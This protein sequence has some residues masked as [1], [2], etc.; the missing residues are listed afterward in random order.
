MQLKTKEILDYYKFKGR[1]NTNSFIELLKSNP[2]VG[3]QGIHEGQQKIIDAYEE[4]VEPSAEAKS[5]GLEFEYKYSVLVAAC[6]RRFGKSFVTAIIGAA[7]LLVPNSKTMVVSLTLDNAGV[8]FDL[9]YKILGGLG[10]IDELTINRRRDMELE[11]PNGSTLRVASVENV[12]SKLGS[13]ISLLILDEARLFRK[14]LY[15]Q[16]LTPMLLDFS[17][18]SRVLLISS[19]SP[20]WFEEA[21]NQGQSEDPKWAKHWSINLPTHTNPTI[22]RNILKEYE[23]TMPKA[24]YEQEVL[25]LF[26]SKHGAVFPEFDQVN[27]V[28]SD[29]DFPYFSEWL[30]CGNVIIQTIDSGYSHFFASQWIV[31]VEEVDTYFVF[32]E[33]MKN[34]TLTP[35]HAENI[36]AIE[37]D[38]GIQDIIQL[39][40]AD[41]AAS[42]QLADF[43]E[44]GLYYTKAEK[45]LRE[46]IN[47]LNTLLFQRSGVTGKPR[48]LIHK[49]CHETIRQLNEVQWKE[50]AAG[51][52]REQS[53]QGVK[54]FK[55][56]T[57]NDKTDW[58]LID[59]LRYGMNAFA[60]NNGIGMSSFDTV[61]GE[62]TEDDEFKFSMATAGFFKIG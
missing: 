57:G 4:R 11:M 27:N 16:I 10:L 26:T 56:D 24:L 1:I 47:N 43:S 40:F 46:T 6:G 31:Y 25:G 5:L 22:P 28:Y 7:E 14:E 34:K 32:H 49:N 2:N 61:A 30:K 15:S 23:E 39:R 52:T 8:I 20:G 58:D 19:P 59:S 54:P 3:I 35:T 13:A 38:Y 33:Y 42:Q 48:L 37:E 50:D 9:I 44:Y 17:P 41:P 45:N 62:T 29:S 55:A 60:K 21:Y 18:L 36:H 12:E 51:Q 53:A